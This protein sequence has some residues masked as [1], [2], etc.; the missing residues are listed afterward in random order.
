MDG[1]RK[2]LKDLGLSPMKVEFAKH[3]G[4]TQNQISDLAKQVAGGFELMDKRMA[5]HERLL[6]GLLNV[7]N[8]KDVLSAD[9]LAKLVIPDERD[10]D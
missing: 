10:S 6:I 2:E 5:S 8:Y 1:F 9:E 4:E 7:L 3:Y